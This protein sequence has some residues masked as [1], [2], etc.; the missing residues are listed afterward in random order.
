MIEFKDLSGIYQI[1][2]K[3][4]GQ[5][6]IGSSIDLLK[7]FSS[8][9]SRL[10]RNEHRNNYLQN[11]WNKYGQENFE[12]NVLF[13]IY[14]TDRKFLD[15]ILLKREKEYI[16]L[17]K[18]N[19]TENGYNLQIVKNN[20]FIVS[21]E[22]R[23]KIKKARAKQTMPKWTEKRKERMKVHMKTLHERKKGK[24]SWNKGK[25][26]T[27]EQTKLFSEAQN[28]RKLAV[29]QL[30]LDGKFVNKFESLSEANRKTGIHKSSIKR[31]CEKRGIQAGNFLWVYEK[32]YDENK[33]Y[34][35]R[36]P[37]YNKRAYMK[38]VLQF[39]LEMNL[40]EEHESLCSAANKTGFHKGNIGKVC[41]EKQ[42]TAYG[43]KWFYKDNYEKLMMEALL[44]A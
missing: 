19:S 29:I 13:L 8:H 33:E 35:A 36:K 9:K 18:S 11:A 25:K 14:D 31:I 39:D 4:T 24:P 22:T 27:K 34:K 41:K 40:I 30:T 12:F 16:T 3:I 42:N 32:D 2:N 10:N 6:Y 21:E 37:D 15:E 26:L 17:H 28:H 20:R 5:S 23:E 7:R 44:S 1:K 43:F 38:P